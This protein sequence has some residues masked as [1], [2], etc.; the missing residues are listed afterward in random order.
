MTIG[1]EQPARLDRRWPQVFGLLLDLLDLLG[2]HGRSP[3][4]P[5]RLIGQAVAS[6]GIWAS[7]TL[8]AHPS[9]ALSPSRTLWIVVRAMPVIRKILFTGTPAA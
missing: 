4:G 5:A 9:P 3:L 7:F 6:L 1:A 8:A 2:H